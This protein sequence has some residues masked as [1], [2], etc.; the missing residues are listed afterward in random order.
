VKENNKPLKV[1]VTGGSG[2]I[3][4]NLIKYYLNSGCEVLNIDIKKPQCSSQAASWCEQDILDRE[5]LMSV[6]SEFSPEYVI[7]MAARTDLRG[8]DI[9][10]YTSNTVGV[11]NV[12]E[13]LN[14]L[15]NIKRVIYASSMLVCRLGYVPTSDFDYNPPNHYGESKVIGENFVR[16]NSRPGISWVIVR[17]TSIW[18]PWFGTPYKQF[19]DA[20]KNGYYFHPKGYD[21]KRSYGFILNCVDIIDSLLKSNKKQVDSSTY[22]LCDYD[23]T[24]ILDL[25]NTIQRISN[26]KIVK[27]VPFALL[28]IAAYV[29]DALMCIGYTSP[30]LTSFR[31]DNMLTDAIFETSELK[32][33]NGPL[34]YS[35]K[36]G[37]RL[38]VD[39]M[40]R[41]E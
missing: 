15:R 40:D 16:K 35:I 6:I 3:G 23:V 25:A 27:Q 10:D 39:W 13:A 28:R 2:F 30:P 21:L 9:R 36:E 5:G 14:N 19:F 12:V 18:G 22:Y 26:A 7:H 38:T 32:T 34:R 8:K 33:I 1:L 20:V 11:A 17:P 24:H 29:G 37:V 31:L 41:I 4:T